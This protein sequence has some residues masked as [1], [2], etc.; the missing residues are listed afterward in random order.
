MHSLTLASLVFFGIVFG[1]TTK[2][3]VDPCAMCQYVI[4]Q[5]QQHYKNG[6]SKG[7]V[8]QELSNDCDTLKRFYGDQAVK[9]CD[10][11][12]HQN[13]D[14]IYCDLQHGASTNQICQDM[15]E[16]AGPSPGGTTQMPNGCHV[17]VTTGATGAT[18]ATA[19]A[20]VAVTT[21]T[22]ST[23]TM[24]T[25][26]PT[27]TTTTMTT[28][29]PVDPC[30]ICISVIDTARNYFNNKVTDEAALK[31]ELLNLCQ[32]LSSAYD[33]SV[34]QNCVNSVNQYIDKI[35]VDLVNGQTSTSVCQDMMQCK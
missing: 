11:W 7:A 24:T 26:T 17:T 28:T 14:V 32:S 1:Q 15:G 23:T 4:N 22:K 21:T 8:Q 3:P 31:T 27:T 5:A 25:T 35:F 18:G 20:S 10:H 2:A 16:C 19:T 6:E 33:Q 12:V 29:T 30:P 9:D 34:V 13:I